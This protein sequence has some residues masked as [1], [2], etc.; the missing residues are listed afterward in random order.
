[1]SFFKKL[2]GCKC[3]KCCGHKEGCDCCKDKEKCC[4]EQASAQTEQSAPVSE[5]TQTPENNPQM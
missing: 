3:K 1:M 5:P 4:K 2:F